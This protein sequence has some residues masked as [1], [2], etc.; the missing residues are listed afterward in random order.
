MKVLPAA[1]WYLY[2]RFVLIWTKNIGA[3]AAHKMLVK[4]TQGGKH[5]F[6]LFSFHFRAKK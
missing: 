1:Y 3:K 5:S 6:I 4:L 2:F